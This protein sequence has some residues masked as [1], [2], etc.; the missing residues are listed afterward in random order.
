MMLQMQKYGD[1]TKQTNPDP[2]NFMNRTP[3]KLGAGYDSVGG[4]EAR[5]PMRS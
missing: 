4:R 5:P 1:M 2:N 3:I